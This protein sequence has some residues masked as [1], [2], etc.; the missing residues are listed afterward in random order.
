MTEKEYEEEL[1]M[2]EAVR[3]AANNLYEF[4]KAGSLSPEISFSIG[5]VIGRLHKLE[6]EYRVVLD[7]RRKLDEVSKD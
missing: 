2:A 6:M 3:K 5:V 7:L 1:E 4:A